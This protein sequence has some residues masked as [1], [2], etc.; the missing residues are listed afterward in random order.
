MHEDN[1][2]AAGKGTMKSDEVTK[3]IIDLFLKVAEDLWRSGPPTPGK[4]GL[5]FPLY[6]NGA[7]CITEKPASF[8]FGHHAASISQIA[9]A[10]EGPTKGRGFG[11]RHLRSS[12]CDWCLFDAATGASQANIEFKSGT[13]GNVVADMRKLLRDGLDGGWFCTI[14]SGWEAAF[15]QVFN[16]LGAALQEVL[17]EVPPMRDNSHGLT[18]AVCALSPREV[19]WRSF[20]PGELTVQLATT[21]FAD[22]KWEEVSWKK[23]YPHDL[24]SEECD[25]IKSRKRRR[26][27]PAED[28]G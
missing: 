16:G 28:A 15:N 20:E 26:P 10:P 27:R 13:S 25:R 23:N 3:I 24:T 7:V 19:M 17:Q 1:R 11:K 22:R 14:E 2:H 18:I 8:L 9:F 5:V 6:F 21:E 4:Q 12:L